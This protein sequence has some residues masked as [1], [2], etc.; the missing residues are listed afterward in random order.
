M[1][2]KKKVLEELEQMTLKVVGQDGQV[3]HFKIKKNTPLRKLMHAYC[4]RSNLA[5]KTIRFV[6]D[7]QRISENDTPKVLD[8]D[9]GAIIEVFT[10]QSGGGSI[11]Q[12]KR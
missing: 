11:R 2:D 5:V 7:G 1:D 10:Q 4:D 6:F 12:S 8:M 9:D 3:V